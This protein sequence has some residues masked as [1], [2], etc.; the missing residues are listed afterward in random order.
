MSAILEQSALGWLLDAGLK[1]AVLL[2]AAWLVVLL[3][4]RASAATHHLVLTS[5]LAGLVA[6]PLLTPVLPPVHLGLLPS[7]ETLAPLARSDATAGT[8]LI[9]TG[10]PGAPND[11]AQLADPAALPAA[12]GTAAAPGRVAPR[13]AR[14]YSLLLLAIWA[15]GA[16]L[17]AGRRI[18][19]QVRLSAVVRRAPRIRRAAPARLCS[20]LSVEAGLARTPELCQSA[21]IAVPITIGWR[22]PIIVLPADASE[23]PAARLRTVLLHELAHIARVD[24]AL[25]WFAHIGCALHWFNPLAWLTARRYRLERERA[26]DDFVLRHGVPPTDYADA[27]LCVAQAARHQRLARVALAM[28]CRS[29]FERRVVDILDGRRSHASLRPGLASGAL[30]ICLGLLAT[31]GTLRVWSRPAAS[32]AAALPTLS[33]APAAQTAAPT[34]FDPQLQ[35]NPDMKRSRIA[36]LL[37]GTALSG[38]VMAQETPDKDAPRAEPTRTERRDR[39]GGAR[40]ERGRFD[41]GEL[42]Q[43]MA[44]R[45]SE[46][47]ELDD[48]QRA[49]LDE[50]VAKQR[51]E[52]QA[53]RERF[54]KLREAREAG[55]TETVE[56]LEAEIQQQR[57]PGR[58]ND[59]LSQFGEQIR[60]ILREDQLVKFDEMRA[61]MQSQDGRRG[62]GRGGDDAT[63]RLARELPDALKLDDAQREEFSALLDAE[64][65]KRS[66]QMRPLFEEMR[67]AREEGDDAKVEE[68]RAKLERSR[69]NEDEG[70]ARLFKSVEKLLHDDQKTLLSDFRKDF[71][72]QRQGERALGDDVRNVLR[73]AKRLR[74]SDE[75]ST[76]LRDIERSAQR[77][78]R[79]VKRDDKDAQTE[80]ATR[81]R[82]EIEK[83]LTQEQQ[84]DFERGLER[85]GERR[86]G[87]RGERGDGRRGDGE[88]D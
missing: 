37:A 21:D 3:A 47:L 22:R 45:V 36:S 65:E 34:R 31:L 33:A 35:R 50:I 60:P 19:G 71:E 87:E 52:L 59:P 29:D 9:L 82:A 10:D 86:R 64:R 56:R 75:Q 77:D 67:A 88:R 73:A 1:G 70:L 42:M 51:Q 30:L 11:S 41:S 38:G 74:L 17:I 72:E 46:E 69:P 5:A 62:R 32:G 18:V 39:D 81:V 26:C 12:A 28:A 44:A 49:Q 63:G 43:R 14:N 83:I 13:A 25:Q 84:E 15:A 4:R 40:G 7:I 80:I 53:S 61:R 66:E 54:G 76:Q 16:L 20:M 24:A 23:W 8:A 6:L 55:D 2:A 85:G 58:G 27:L 78:A 68:L 79:E 48:A 57:R